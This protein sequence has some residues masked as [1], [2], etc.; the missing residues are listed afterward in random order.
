M[1]GFQIAISV[2]GLFL[3][4]G[5]LICIVIQCSWT[6]PNRLNSDNYTKNRTE[7]FEFN[8]PEDEL[9]LDF[10]DKSDHSFGDNAEK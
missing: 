2:V 4:L 5:S 10:N 7:S 3:S 8:N 9:F 1:F 6:K